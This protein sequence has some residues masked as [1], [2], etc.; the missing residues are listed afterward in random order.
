M[1]VKASQLVSGANSI[2]L[3]ATDNAGNTN[4]ATVSITKDITAPTGAT[5]TSPSNQWYNTKPTITITG[6]TDDTTETKDILCYI[7]VDTSASPSTI[8][9]GISPVSHTGSA[10]TI[11]VSGENEAIG[12]TWSQS[13]KLY[14]H[15]VLEDKVGNKSEI[16]SKQFKYDTIKPTTPTTANFGFTKAYYGSTTAQMTFSFADSDA[17]SGVAKIILKSVSGFPGVVETA[18]FAAT[19]SK[20]VTLTNTEG[21][22]RV[23]VAFKDAAG[24]SSDWS[25][26]FAST[27]LDTTAPKTTVVLYEP[28]SET[29]YKK[30]PT[31]VLAT[32][33][34]ITIED[35]AILEQGTGSYLLWEGGESDRP[36]SGW[37]EF[38][39]AEDKNYIFVAKTASAGTGDK[40]FS[41]VVR[42]ASGNESAVATSAPFYYN[43]AAPG[44]YI[45]TDFY[46]ISKV[47]TLRR[48]SATAVITEK[49]NDQVVIDVFIGDST[50][51][52]STT[53]RM[54]ACKVCAYK[55]QAE[56]EAGTYE[57]TAIEGC[58][59]NLDSTGT[60]AG[61]GT[62]KAE[63]ETFTITGANYEKALNGGAE[64]TESGS[65]DG[66]HFVVV[67]ILN[68]ANT[69]SGHAVFE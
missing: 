37:V 12:G 17:T 1:T 25:E 40:R 15:V 52:V 19:T 58:T 61:S 60:Q 63:K 3:T 6:I 48:S 22:H 67:Y 53:D 2:V 47:H 68:E 49:Y 4:T 42:D 34:K 32:N 16:F 54:K 21:E 27:Y 8:L 56:A 9:A 57:D 23:Q 45:M 28:G 50:G 46:N 29:T 41:V 5:I 64:I 59:W 43:P 13:D 20:T 24:N 31:N 69:W 38:T 44:A 62:P 55:T 65:L 14:V 11:S 30:T 39:L 18:E 66:A 33:V 7:W 26:D 51:A 35:T 10:G 36:E